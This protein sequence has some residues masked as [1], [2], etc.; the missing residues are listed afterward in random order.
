MLKVNY[1]LWMML[2]PLVCLYFAGARFRT[3]RAID[4]CLEASSSVPR[5]RSVVALTLVSAIYRPTSTIATNL[6][7]L[8]ALR[9]SHRSQQ[10]QRKPVWC[11]LLPPPLSPRLPSSSRHLQI[12]ASHPHL[13]SP[14]LL[15]QWHNHPQMRSWSLHLCLSSRHI[16][17]LVTVVATSLAMMWPTRQSPSLPSLQLFKPTLRLLLL[18][19]SV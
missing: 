17:L 16:E 18:Q 13:S 3:P 4:A 9:L 5:T 14:P 1:S 15:P 12:S 6:R 2:K 7:I 11:L 10:L 19:P 8:L